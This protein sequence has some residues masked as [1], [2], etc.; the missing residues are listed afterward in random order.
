[1]ETHPISLNSRGREDSPRGARLLGNKY[2]V[3]MLDE[4][5]PSILRLILETHHPSHPLLFVYLLQNVLCKL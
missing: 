3:K 1:M 5:T 2:M 4:M